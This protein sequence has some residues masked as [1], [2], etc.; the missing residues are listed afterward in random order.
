MACC[1]PAL[2]H[3][4]CRAM[5]W[6]DDEMLSATDFSELGVG[7]LAA[8][9]PLDV[10]RVVEGVARRRIGFR[11][12]TMLMLSPDGDEVQRLYTTDPI[13][14]PVSGRER[15]GTTPWGRLV[16]VEQHPYLGADAN[17]VRWAFPQDFDLIESL[18]LG[19]TVNIPIVNSGTTLGSLN[20]LDQAHY[21]H[22]GH[23]HAAMNLAPYLAAPFLAV[24]SG[25]TP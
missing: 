6:G 14:Y 17:S 23:L 2:R 25:R 24:G 19:S 16:F 18:G 13:H 12:L 9:R 10:F 21:Y 1:A 15:L 5:P 4:S 3:A 7:Y 20:I 11:L 22:E 8:R